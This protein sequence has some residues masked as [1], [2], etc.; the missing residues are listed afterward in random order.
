MPNTPIEV[1]KAILS[2]A[3]LEH[4]R[5]IIREELQKDFELIGLNTEDAE[6]R[7]ALQLDHAFVRRWRMML[8]AAASKIGWVV[9]SAILVGIGAVFMA[10][11][12][13]KFGK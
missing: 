6:S 8:D 11:W 13:A 10:G 1:Q 5:A 2:R 12:Q 4:I 7:Q 9:I 3:D